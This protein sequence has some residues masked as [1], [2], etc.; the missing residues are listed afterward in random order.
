MSGTETLWATP[1]VQAIAWALVH[2][3]W[4]GALVGLAAAAALS[5]LKKSSA[6][7]RYAVAAGALLLM[8][9]LPVATAVRLARSPA[10][11]TVIETPLHQTSPSS[12]GGTGGRLGEEGRGDEGLSAAIPSPVPAALPWI[13]SLWLAGVAFLSIYHLGGFL[14][15]RR[16][17]R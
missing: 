17:T 2:F 4:Q 8:V 15:T 3:L 6:A 10:G 5:L 12:P 14:Q 16:L 1:A 7:V 13:L 9:A 11:P